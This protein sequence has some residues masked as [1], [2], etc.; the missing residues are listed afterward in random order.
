MN[1]I[2]KEKIIIDAEISLDEVNF[3]NYKEIEKLE[4]YG[5]GNAKPFFYFK[6]III[7]EV[8]YFGKDKEHLELVFKN[9]KNYTIKAITFYFKEN[10]DFEFKKSDKI[11]MVASIEFNRF[12]GSGYLRLKIE[13]VF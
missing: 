7:F 2:I 1:K 5:M 3:N 4:P 12:N 10:L 13:D 8:N 6:N 9:S 11:N